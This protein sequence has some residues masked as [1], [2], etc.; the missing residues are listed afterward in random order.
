MIFSGVEKWFLPHGLPGLY[1]FWKGILGHYFLERAF[2]E[3][4][5]IWCFRVGDIHVAS[6]ESQF[7]RDLLLESFVF[8]FFCVFCNWF[9]SDTDA[10]WTA[11]FLSTK[12][13][14][15]PCEHANSQRD[16]FHLWYLCTSIFTSIYASL[17]R[18]T[19][20]CNPVYGR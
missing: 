13:I 10:R 17:Y 20:Y 15:S 19:I 11:V 8:V 7:F 18:T 12:Y 3:S 6:T 2:W 1:C 5:W 4:L 9:G 16:I 14:E